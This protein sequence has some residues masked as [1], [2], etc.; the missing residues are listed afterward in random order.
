MIFEYVAR[1]PMCRLISA[2]RY[3]GNFFKCKNTKLA[4]L[5]RKAKQL[6]LNV[7]RKF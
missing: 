5:I 1:K 2:V 4:C 6:K 3:V 7:F